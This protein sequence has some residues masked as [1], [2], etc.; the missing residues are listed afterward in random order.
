MTDAD[1]AKREQPSAAST[2]LNAVGGRTT[3]FDSWNAQTEEQ[4][5]R[6]PRSWLKVLAIVGGV[7]LGL[8]VI[9]VLVGALVVVL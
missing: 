6:A 9:G 5:P 3:R 8:V 2:F 4:H 7:L 1:D